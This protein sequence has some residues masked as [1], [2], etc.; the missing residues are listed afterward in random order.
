MY[1]WVRTY[2]DYKS[3]VLRDYSFFRDSFRNRNRV[4]PSVVGDRS[5]MPVHWLLVTH[6]KGDLVTRTLSYRH[7][8]PPWV[9]V[10]PTLLINFSLPLTR[11]RTGGN[12]HPEPY[13][14]TC[15][16]FLRLLCQYQVLSSKTTKFC[17]TFRQSD[18]LKRSKKT[19][20]PKPQRPFNISRPNRAG[21]TSS[22]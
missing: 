22:S 19:S 4:T 1:F 15:T 17:I 16:V 20:R 8:L 2:K 3:S 12:F 9:L 13:E 11:E 10:C 18:D 21:E 5:P 6:K 7:I 14:R